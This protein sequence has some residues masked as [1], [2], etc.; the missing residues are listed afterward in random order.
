MP[1]V[2]TSRQ[3]LVEMTFTML[4]FNSVKKLKNQQADK[5]KEMLINVW[6]L[7]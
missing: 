1:S 5:K 6:V 7:K 3:K 4:L 2:R